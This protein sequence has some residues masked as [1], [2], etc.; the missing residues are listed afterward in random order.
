LA[1][2][3]AVEPISPDV[4]ARIKHRVMERIAHA[5]TRHQSLQAAEGIWQSFKQGV[6]IKVLNEAEGVMSCL[7][8]LAPVALADARRL[9]VDEERVV[10]EGVERIGDELVL[11]D[12]GFHM[13]L[14]D[15]L[16]AP[17]RSEQ[18]AT[19][20]LRGGSPHVAELV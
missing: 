12:G 13:A 3:Q 2:H 5:E 7:L 17:I 11:P 16:H 15:T 1:T 8:R 4:S 10:L 19:L 14:K 20:F 6:A 18:G 9:P